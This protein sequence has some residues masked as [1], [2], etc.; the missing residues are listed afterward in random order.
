MLRETLVL[1]PQNVGLYTLG[2]GGGGGL[3]KCTVCTI[4]KMLKF[5]DGPM[6]WKL[7]YCQIH[8]CDLYGMSCKAVFNKCRTM[9]YI[10]SSSRTTIL[11]TYVSSPF[12]TKSP[13]YTIGNKIWFKASFLP[14]RAPHICIVTRSN[15]V[16]GW[17]LNPGPLSLEESALLTELMRWGLSLP[18][19]TH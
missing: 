14:G 1:E 8:H 16:P 11:T 4:F 6:K 19:C 15:A 2:G 17:D 18:S 5:V 3:K 13:L 9:Y 12:Q 7:Y 10:S